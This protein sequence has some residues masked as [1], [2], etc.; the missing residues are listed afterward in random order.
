[1]R[2]DKANASVPFH[3]PTLAAHTPKT[4]PE[5]HSP[6]KEITRVLLIEDNPGEALLLRTSLAELDDFPVEVLHARTLSMGID[7]LARE[8]IEVVLLDLGLPDSQGLDTVTKLI[9]QETE[10]PIVVLTGL[11]D[12]TVALEAMKRGA[13]DFLVK[14]ALVDSELLVRTIR[15]SIERKRAEL[16]LRESNRQLEEALRE[17]RKAQER[18]VLQERMKALGQ[19]AS[20]IAHDFNNAL[21][22]IV[23]YSDL[24]RTN[25]KVFGAR[26]QSFVEKIHTAATI[27]VKRLQEFYRREQYSEESEL[28]NFNQVVEQAVALTRP[29]WKDQIKAFGIE[30]NVETELGDLP[31]TEAKEAELR[32]LLMNLIF[33][34]VDATSEGGTV[35]ISTSHIAD[36][37]QVEVKDTGKGM[38]EEVLSRCYEPFYSTKPNRG[39]GMG[40]TMVHG[41]VQRHDGSIDI[42]SR[43]GE[44]TTVTIGFPVRVKAAVEEEAR[45]QE[46]EVSPRKVLVV[47]D[48]APVR[49]VIRAFLSMGGHQ[50]ETANDGTEGFEA[51]ELGKFDLVILDRS[52][53]KMDGAR[54]AMLIKEASPET[55]IIMLT[56]FGEMLGTVKGVDTILGKP[57]TSA[58]LLGAVSAIVSARTGG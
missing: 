12:K 14:D 19:M 22:P 28:V 50:V 11:D 9:S 36:H 20:G 29:R 33:N 41:I 1:M 48:E 30:I 56:G 38:S 42:Q 45:A 17:L 57:I 3:K 40:L 2:L 54:L 5:Q 8:M 52:M 24:L 55:P 58:A 32:D 31:E 51:F 6:R 7:W 49:E 47:E 21:V 26:E 39:S 4:H 35:T 23:A 25:P 37:I 15:Y 44:G 13:Q 43:L 10:V 46:K 53:P 27:V 16:A 34:A 18:I